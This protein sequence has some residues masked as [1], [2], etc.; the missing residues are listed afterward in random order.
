MG[1]PAELIQSGRKAL[2]P[3]DAQAAKEFFLRLAERCGDF[4]DVVAQAEAFPPADGCE[5]VAGELT[6]AGANLNDIPRAIFFHPPG[7]SQCQRAVERGHCG[8]VSP[9]PYGVDAGGVV[10]ERGMIERRLHEAV[11]RD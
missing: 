4:D 2:V 8:K 7:D 9:A 5:D 6:A 3:C 10:A 11:K 1:A